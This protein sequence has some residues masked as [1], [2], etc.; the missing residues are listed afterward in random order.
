MYAQIKS[1][2]IATADEKDSCIPMANGLKHQIEIAILAARQAGT[3]IISNLGKP[4]RVKW[5]AGR[6][7]VTDVDLRAQETIV[8]IIKASFPG[9]D[10]LAEEGSELNGSPHIWII[11]PLDG[12]NNYL[13]Q[14][15]CFCTSIALQRDG[16]IVLGVVY[17][18]L[19]DKLF[20]TRGL[21]TSRTANLTETI[22]GIDWPANDRARED[23]LKLATAITHNARTLRSFGSAALSLCYVA[24]GWLDGFIHCDIEP[25]D[26]A[27]GALIVQEAGG[28]VTDFAGQPWQIDSKS[29][30]ASNGSLHNKILAM[31]GMA[32]DSRRESH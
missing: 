6:D 30:I 26:A 24:A 18:P 13:N 10:I 4:H 20:T 21:Q 14:L 23:T 9:H 5:K 17:D 32:I 12:T 15:P 11:D 19:N 25:W 1:G 3:I 16:D 2:S 28:K 7:L 22:I 29:L 8:G 31:K 27:A